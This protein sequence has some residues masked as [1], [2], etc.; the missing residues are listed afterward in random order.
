EFG[1]RALLDISEHSLR[2]PRIAVGSA[3]P[4]RIVHVADVNELARLVT[5]AAI[6][7]RRIAEAVDHDVVLVRHRRGK[8][9]TTPAL[10]DHPR[11][12][13]RVLLH[14]LTLLLGGL[15]RLVE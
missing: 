11:P 7:V 1:P 12:G 15:A 8:V 4:K 9:E 10:D 3:R 14:H 5:I 2:F 13:N 6:V